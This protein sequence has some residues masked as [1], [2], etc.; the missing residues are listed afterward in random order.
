V[1][2]WG[3]RRLSI[4]LTF[5]SL[6]VSG[7][8]D[9]AQ[10]SHCEYQLMKLRAESARWEREKEEL[11]GRRGTESLRV[12]SYNDELL[13]VLSE[14]QIHISDQHQRYLSCSRCRQ[15]AK[16]MT[17]LSKKIEHSIR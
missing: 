6:L 8:R 7:A 5:C 10:P 3:S 15:L 2:V 4:T 16:K 17:E 13:R 14:F 1:L 11:N 12:P 9:Q